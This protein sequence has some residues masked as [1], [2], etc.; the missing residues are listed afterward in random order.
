MCWLHPP[1][2]SRPVSPLP[3]RSNSRPLR[4]SSWTPKLW[5][6]TAKRSRSSRSKC[7]P[8]V[9]A[10][11]PGPPHLPSTL[12]RPPASGSRGPV[13]RLPC[14]RG[15]CPSTHRLQGAHPLPSRLQGA[16][17]PIHGLRGAHPLLSR[18]QGP[19]P[20]PPGSR[21]TASGRGHPSWPWQHGRQLQLF[22]SS[23]GCQVG[24][25]RS[26]FP[27]SLLSRKVRARSP[28]ACTPTNL[29]TLTGQNYV[30]SPPSALRETRRASIRRRGE[31][32]YPARPRSIP[33]ALPSIL[34]PPRRWMPRR[35][36]CRCVCTPLT[37]STSMERWVPALLPGGS[38]QGAGSDWG[39]CEPGS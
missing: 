7:S 8:P 19:V 21:G 32:G 26:Q 16:H 39:V 3:F 18:L 11:L 37:S 12:S 17:P 4:P 38:W 25:G 28:P 5:P 2:L 1:P 35:S 6:G 29:I 34:P 27:T 10:R 30:P 22:H 36:R 31:W 33:Q 9:N 13:P 23:P 20:R 15:A 24:W 14:S